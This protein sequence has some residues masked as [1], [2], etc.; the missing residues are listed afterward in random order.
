MT[1]EERHAYFLEQLKI[2]DEWAE[3]VAEKI[4]QSGKHAEATPLEVAQFPGEVQEFTENEK[5]IL[6]DQGRTLEV[7]SRS[8]SFTGIHDY[9]YGTVFV[10]TVEGWLQKRSYPVAVAVVSQ[11]TGG[12]VMIP[13]KTQ[14]LW[15]ERT[16]FDGKRG[17]E[18]T[19]FEC[20]RNLLR[21]FEEF[22]GW[23]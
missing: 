11:V 2:G 7:K 15:G 3:Y 5:D 8:V 4:R 9:P 17:F 12:V 21:S 18:I 16:V 20:E 19:V 23:L 14:P 13:V 1:P 22:V 6:L 10:D